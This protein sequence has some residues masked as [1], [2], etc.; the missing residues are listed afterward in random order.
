MASMQ[1]TLSYLAAPVWDPQR[2]AA[3]APELQKILALAAPPQL[4]LFQAT[5]TTLLLTLPAAD[6]AAGDTLT[7]QKNARIDLAAAVQGSVTMGVKQFRDIYNALFDPR[8]ALLSGEVRVT[9]GTDIEHIPFM[10]RIDEMTGV[11]WTSTVRWTRRTTSSPSPAQCDRK[12]GPHRGAERRHPPGNTPIASSIV[13]MT[14][15]LPAD[16]APAGADP[17]KAPPGKMNVTLGP[18]P[19]RA[20][21]QPCRQRDRRRQPGRRRGGHHGRRHVRQDLHGAAQ[22][23][24]GVRDGRP[25]SDLA[26]DHARPDRRPITRAVAVKLVAAMLTGPKPAGAPSRR[27]AIR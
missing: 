27:P 24:Q 10:A 21:S 23:Q 2:I 13:G 18:A 14:P 9:I 22:H 25:E 19:D 26:C 6:P 8:N 1:M 16:L 4:A 5:G 15:A 12:P 20:L 7:E 3:A 17:K 11:C